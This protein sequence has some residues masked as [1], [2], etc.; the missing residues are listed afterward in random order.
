MARIR[1]AIEQ[2][3]KSLDL[4][5]LKGSCVRPK[6]G[7][8]LP[9][10]DQSSTDSPNGTNYESK[11]AG[12]RD[13]KKK[14]DLTSS[15][16]NLAPNVTEASVS[17]SRARRQRALKSITGNSLLLPLNAATKA[18]LGAEPRVKEVRDQNLPGRRTPRR[19]VM[20]KVPEVA[21]D[22]DDETDVKQAVSSPAGSSYEEKD[23]SDDS[24]SG[25]EDSLELIQF[26]GGRRPR[27]T[28]QHR[29]LPSPSQ[30]RKITPEPVTQSET[31]SGIIDLT[32]SPSPKKSLPAFRAQP[33]PSQISRPSSS[34]NDFKAILTF[35][36]KTT[37]STRKAPPR[38]TTPPATTPP[39]S[40][41]KGKIT[42]PSKNT[43][44]IARAPFRPSIDAFW[45]AT[46]VNEWNDQY[47]PKKDCLTSPRKKRFQEL[48]N[49]SNSFGS[50][51]DEGY[52][53]PTASVRKTSPTK[54][55]A[56]A[57]KLKKD[58]EA[59]KHSIAEQFLKELDDRITDGKISS[60]AEST[61]GVKL[62]WSR[63]LN[64]TAGRANWRRETIRRTS[65]D[66][67]K[68]TEY[69]HE[70][71]I[72]LAEKVI[73]DED[74]LVNVLAHEFCHLANF[75]I[76]GVKDR[77]HGRE[78]KEWA[79]R[80][81]K[82]FAGRG[83]QVTT[84]HSYAIEYKYVWECENCGLEFKRHSKSIDPKTHS[85]GSCKSK[86][87]QTKPVPRSGGAG[88]YAGFV[89]EHFAKVKRESPGASHG[90]VMEKLGKL[91]K[92]QKAAAAAK[93]SSEPSKAAV[94]DIANA[95]GVITL[96]G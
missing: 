88:G 59:R 19:V 52:E 31:S 94:D 24:E 74:R 13:G 75:M 18:E 72:E 55:N 96:D 1:A 79:A 26:W 20:H 56:A 27:P 40:P 14:Q 2:T 85:C 53:S 69:R 62:V 63:T 68:T 36:P 12:E 23:E 11:R 7:L 28:P 22:E 61:G 54:K 76:S 60:L 43:Q 65:S 4:L 78:F 81:S 10:Q 47:S 5:K 86:L 33:L 84:K 93:T 73:D 39:P 67:T 41:S 57:L 49:R 16:P 87:V 17:D 58:F 21:C 38:P 25:Q 50:D 45:S 77:P 37:R 83:V 70:A 29:R 6:A 15:L 48:Q 64:S 91:Y 44:P 32:S 92:E 89:K 82:A 66:G 95:L 8:R 80:A 34:D 35:N 51:G 3:D 90:A 46:V 9:K 71:S 30:Q 42:S